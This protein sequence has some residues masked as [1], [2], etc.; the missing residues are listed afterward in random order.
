MESIQS[1]IK[2]NQP[3][4][5][6]PINWIVSTNR[7]LLMLE[8]SVSALRRRQK[9]VQQELKKPGLAA[10]KERLRELLT[11]LERISR[12]LRQSAGGLQ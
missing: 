7:F 12:A 5:S 10:D 2:P 4:S 3:E 1:E 11:E 9:K 8:V 6:S